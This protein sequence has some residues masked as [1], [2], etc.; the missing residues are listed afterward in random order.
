MLKE[1]QPDEA[2]PHFEQALRLTFDEGKTGEAKTYYFLGNAFLDKGKLGMA[3]ANYQ[4]A[5]Q[6]HSEYDADVHNNLG[7]ALLGQ[8][9][10]DQ[11]IDQYQQ[12]VELRSRLPKTEQAKAV[13]NLA[14]ALAQKGRLD[15]AITYY[16]KAL[17]LHSNYADAHNNLARALIAT[18]RFAEAIR[19]YEKALELAP[20]SVLAQNNLAWQLATCPEPSLRDGARAIKLA[21]QANEVS[22]GKDPII[23]NTLAAGYAENGQ[24][25]KAVE[26]AEEALRLAEAGGDPGLLDVLRRAIALYQAG[27]PYHSPHP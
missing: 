18:Q 12:V 6:Y 7:Q 8:G 22:G 20:H 13:Y 11:A 2:I 23:L 1:H 27:S 5:L 24:S 17:D 26:T 21:E 3:I 9:L 19:H 4:K 25:S 16:N 14:N 10:V 15:D